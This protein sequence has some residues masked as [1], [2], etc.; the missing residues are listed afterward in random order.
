MLGP[1]TDP[2]NYLLALV[3]SEVQEALVV[4][5]VSAVPGAL[6]ALAVPEV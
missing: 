5:E 2:P 3:V 4:L 1:A 6:E